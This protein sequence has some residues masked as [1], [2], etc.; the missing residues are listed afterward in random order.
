MRS[1]NPKGQGNCW[2]CGSDLSNTSAIWHIDHYPV[3]W[4]DIKDQLCCGITSELDERNLVPSC[5]PCNTSHAH[6]APGHA[7]YCGRT[8]CCCLRSVAERCALL[9][10]TLLL[11]FVLSTVATWVTGW[12]E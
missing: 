9:A 5:A 6:E 10:L 1:K 3:P 11:G 4:R 12:A 8:Q 7:I 2:H